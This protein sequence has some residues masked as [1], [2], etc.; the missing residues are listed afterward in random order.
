MKAAAT[1]SVMIGTSHAATSAT[2][3]RPTAVADVNRA[4]IRADILYG[5]SIDTEC[6]KNTIDSTS[7]GSKPSV[8]TNS[9]VNNRWR[10]S[11]LVGEPFPVTFSG[12]ILD[13]TR[14][15]IDAAATVL[16][17][18]TMPPKC[19]PTAIVRAMWATASQRLSRSAPKR[20]RISSLAARTPSRSSIILLNMINGSR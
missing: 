17:M 3:T 15:M 9:S 11:S 14:R 8:C 1:G 2:F 13:T 16:N 10:M 7:S 12:F 6:S 19:A 18:R 5:T 4:R 20:L